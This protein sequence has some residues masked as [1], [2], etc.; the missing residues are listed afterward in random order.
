MTPPATIA[1]APAAPLT[2]DDEFELDL[3]IIEAGTPL[4]T[5]MCATDDT[6]GSTCSTSACNSASSDPF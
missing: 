2:C 3:R 6:C 5:M 1:V 4:V